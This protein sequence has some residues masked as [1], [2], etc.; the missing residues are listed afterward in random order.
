MTPD[1]YDTRL[2]TQFLESPNEPSYTG[3]QLIWH[4]LYMTYDTFSDSNSVIVSDRRCTNR[5]L[6]KQNII[7]LFWCNM[8]TPKRVI[9]QLSEIYCIIFRITEQLWKG[10]HGRRPRRTHPERSHLGRQRRAELEETGVGRV[11]R[12][13]W[14]KKSTQGVTHTGALLL[15]CRLVVKL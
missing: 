8:R 10:Q 3:K 1:Q 15:L 9:V 12:H 4:L 2:I 13:L 7:P 14:R 6:Y 11:I 5:R